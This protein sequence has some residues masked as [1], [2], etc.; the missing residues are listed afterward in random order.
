M[1][2]E[3]EPVVRDKTSENASAQSGVSYDGRSYQHLT[4]SEAPS[5]CCAVAKKWCSLLVYGSP[6]QP[7]S[8]RQVRENYAEAT[9]ALMFAFFIGGFATFALVSSYTD[10]PKESSNLSIIS[11][12]A[13]F[14]ECFALGVGFVGVR[15]FYKTCKAPRL[16]DQQALLSDR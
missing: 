2:V 5:N 7:L 16:G 13:S 3:L 10:P 8:Q 11:F 4:S 15:K 14:M 12:G 6:Y 1:R 9:F